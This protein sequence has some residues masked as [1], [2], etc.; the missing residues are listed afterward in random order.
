M[1]FLL[2]ALKEYNN[3]HTGDE[4]YT[5][6]KSVEKE[7]Q[8]YDFSGMIVYC[9]CDDP[10]KSAFVKYFR[11]NFHRLGIKCLYA[12]FLETEDN[13]PFLYRYDGVEESRS[14]IES[15]RFQDN[16]KIIKM[17]DIIVTNPPFSN[18]MP[19]ELIKMVIEAGKKFLIIGNY[20]LGGKSEIFPKIQSGEFNCGYSAPSGYA[21]PNGKDKK[22]MNNTLWWTNVGID[23]EPVKLVRFDPTI[24]L[25]YDNYD[26]IN[27]PDVNHI[28]DYDGPMGIP[29]TS[30]KKI[31]PKQFDFLGAKDNLRLNGRKT[32]SR[33]IV[34]L[35]K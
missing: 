20:K 5:N 8:H 6:Y 23:K 31:S 3:Q 18:S 26:A 27:C 4:Y 24:H 32:D 14:R 2:E 9:N 30:I 19:R 25:K 22:R 29:F 17:S 10:D 15:G 13:P 12:T 21:V 1:N 7:L 16:M 35:K 33:Y 28:P 11:D 34:R